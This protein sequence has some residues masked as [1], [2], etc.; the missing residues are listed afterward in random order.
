MSGGLMGMFRFDTMAAFI[1]GCVGVF[2]LLTVMYSIGFMRGRKGVALY[3]VYLVITAAASVGAVF[4]DNLLLFIG[5]WGFLGLPL[6]LLINFEGTE[7]ASQ[8]AKKAF[9]IVG[10]TDAFMLLGLAL[11]WHLCG[12]PAV[13]D[14]TMTAASVRLTSDAAV[15]AYLC[16]AAGALAKAGAVPFHT[17]VPAA[18]EDA[19]APIAAYLPASLDKLLGIYFLARLSL[20]IFVM[21]PAMNTVLM[22]VGSITIVAAVMMALVQHRLKRL[23]GYHAVSQV[24]YMVVGIGTG[25]PLGMAGGLFHMLNHTIYKSALFFTA[26]AVEKRAGSTDLDKL[27]GLSSF[28]PITFV[29]FFIAALAISGVP[30]LNGFASKWMVYQAIVDTG[31]DGGTLWVVW[32][33]AAMI[34]SALTLASFMKLLHAVFL[35]QPAAE[36]NP[37]AVGEAPVSMWVPGAV[38]AGVCVVFGVAPYLIPLGLLIVPSLGEDVAFLGVWQAAPATALIAA[39]LAVGALLYW[40]GS[41][42]KTRSVAPFVGGESVADRP[43]MRVSGADFYRTIEEMPGLSQAYRMA[44]K[45]AFDAYDVGS[46]FTFGFSH[47]LGMLHNGGLLR[48]LAWC[49]L[50]AVILLYVLLRM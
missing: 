37:P 33:L 2:F 40:W 38:L 42:T 26:G 32:L 22:A 23:L 16:L 49:L 43:E 15:I 45:G 5:L 18:A 11:I 46:R 21:T 25:T 31:H 9:I 36:A 3:Y 44:G 47:L 17:W 29:T 30:P 39:A 1:A 8:A 19:P 13:R 50:A 6:Y 34:G 24:G 27:G 7:G 4:A 48:Y 20:D 14:F 41:V 12:Q 10:G 35:G 28:M